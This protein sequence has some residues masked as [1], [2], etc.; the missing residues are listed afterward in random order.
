MKLHQDQISGTNLITAHGPGF[1]TVNGQVKGQGLVVTPESLIEPWGELGFN[2]LD[3]AAFATLAKIGAAITIIGTG[4]HQR[5][6]PPAL[7][8]PLIESRR[9]FEIMD[10]AAACRTYNIL[11]GEGRSVAA[12]LI[13]E[14]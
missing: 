12:A 9:G 13:V 6:P 1:V 2:A 8:R 14:P 7:L 5:F 10:T 11:V 3:E 4:K